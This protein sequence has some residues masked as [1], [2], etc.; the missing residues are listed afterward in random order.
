MGKDKNLKFGMGCTKN[1][2]FHIKKERSKYSHYWG[3]W[4]SDVKYNIFLR[5]SYQFEAKTV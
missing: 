1:N 4:K 5:K 2:I 3:S